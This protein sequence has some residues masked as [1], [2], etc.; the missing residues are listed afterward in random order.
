VRRAQ[1]P[2][3]GDAR[4]AKVRQRSPHLAKGAAC[5]RREQP[6]TWIRDPAPVVGVLHEQHQ[7]HLRVD[8]EHPTLAVHFDLPQ[9]AN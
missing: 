3:H 6:F 8:S 4:S 9:L 2:L 1:W 5:L 7:E